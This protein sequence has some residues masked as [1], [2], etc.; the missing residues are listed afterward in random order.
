M[1]KCL[2]IL[3][4]GDNAEKLEPPYLTGRNVKRYRHFG[5]KVQQHLIKLKRNLEP[6]IPVLCIYP[7]EMKTT[8]TH[9]LACGMFTAALFTIA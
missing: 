4:V 6:A 7:R 8:S 3:S 5:K 2:I 9:K 1:K